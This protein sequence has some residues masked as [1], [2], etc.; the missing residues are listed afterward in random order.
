MQAQA[1]AERTSQQVKTSI[2]DLSYHRGSYRHLDGCHLA[3]KVLQQLLTIQW[4][5]ER[6]VKQHR[7]PDPL[8]PNLQPL[9]NQLATI[10]SPPLGGGMSL[11]PRNHD[12][13]VSSVCSASGQ[14][15]TSLD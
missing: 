10:P 4:V 3:P 15:S 13:S 6:K 12:L 7:V 2:H 5:K 11:Y 9:T 14:Q 1:T 8:A